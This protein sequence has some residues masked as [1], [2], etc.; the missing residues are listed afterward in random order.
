[1][2]EDLLFLARG[3]AGTIDAPKERL[4]LSLTVADVCAHIATLAELKAV[5]LGFAPPSRPI[6]ILANEQAIRRLVLILLDNAV[7]YSR[8]G[9]GVAVSLS[10]EQPEIRLAVRDSGPGIP[11]SERPLI[12][13][14]FYRSPFAR[15]AGQGTGL[16]LSLAAGIAQH[17]GARIQVD[18]TLNEGSTFTVVFP[19]IESSISSSQPEY[20]R[21]LAEPRAVGADLR[22]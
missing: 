1:M 16:G 15:Q 14:R 3:D 21:S 11:D 2:V 7:K 5:S 8:Q 19:S 6:Q 10:I 12:F 22:P 9:G 4:D 18:S 20:G 13:E 17:H